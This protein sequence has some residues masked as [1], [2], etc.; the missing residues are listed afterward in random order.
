MYPSTELSD[1]AA[2]KAV[3]R[4]RV[5]VGRLRCAAYA[6]EAARPLHL[7]DRVITQ[8]RRIPPIAKIAVLPLGLLVRRAVLPRKKV[9]LVGRAI[10]LLPIVMSALKILNARRR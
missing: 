1:L 2:R 10:R 3:I 9:H 4:A 7:L 6:A 8:W 5:S